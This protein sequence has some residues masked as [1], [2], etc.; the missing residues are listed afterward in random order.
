MSGEGLAREKSVLRLK[1]RAA[2][3]AVLPEQRLAS[4]EAIAWRVLA[5]PETQ[6]IGTALLY[7]AAPEEASPHALERALRAAGVRIA[8]PR[9]A[10]SRE[11][12]LHWVD[13]PGVL[14]EGAFGLVE[15]RADAPSASLAEIDLVIVPGIAF[16]ADGNRLGFGGGYYDVLLAGPELRAP[17][18]AIAYDEQVVESVPHDERDRPVDVVVT[19]TRTLRRPTTRS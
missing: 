17:T 15:P 7:G 8:Y 2:R 6:D 5:L 3:R 13:D 9:V 4:A 11:L 14:V 12:A 19:P 1:G 18:A 16:D 10:G